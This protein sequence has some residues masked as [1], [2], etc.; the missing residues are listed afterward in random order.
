MTTE[1]RALFC[2][3]AGEGS[4]Y[5]DAFLKGAYVAI[6]WPE[7]QNLHRVDS[8]DELRARLQE[9]YPDE[10]P[11]RVRN[12]LGQVSNFI[13]RIQIGDFVVTPGSDRSWVCIGK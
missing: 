13:L 12:Y 8:Y 10:P 9:T 5:A 3:W 7:V 4:R 6:G 2:V 11:G 1:Q